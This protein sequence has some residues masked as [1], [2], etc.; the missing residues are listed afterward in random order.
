MKLVSIIVPVYNQEHYLH[1]SLSSILAQTYQEIEVV[2]VND[3]STDTS[4]AII[5]QYSAKDSRLKVVSQENRGLA[6]AIITGIRHASGDFI[7]FVDPDDFIGRHY[8]ENFLHIMSDEDDMVAM[9]F[10]FDQS[11][12]HSPYYLEKTF[13]WKASDLREFVMDVEKTKISNRIFVSRWNKLY[14]ASL[15][16]KILGRLE[17]CQDVSLGEDTLFNTLVLSELKQCRTEATPNAYYYNISNSNSMMKIDVADKVGRI[18]L[19]QMHLSRLNDELNVL[20]KNQITGLSFLL[21]EGV[22]QSLYGGKMSIMKS[23]HKK[24]VHQLNYRSVL[25]EVSQQARSFKT[26]ARLAVRSYLPGIDW[27]LRRVYQVAKK[28]AKVLLLYGVKEPLVFFKD[29]RTKGFAKSW[30]LL[31]HRQKRH[32]AYRDLKRLTPII[33]KRLDQIMSEY[34]E[35]GATYH[36][37]GL[38]QEDERNV[39][40]LWWDGFDKAPPVVKQCMASIEKHYQGYN[41]IKIDHSNFMVYTQLDQE[42][43]EGFETGKISIQTFSDVLRF[44]L[45]KL[46]GGIWMDATLFFAKPLDM[47]SYLEQQSFVSVE[48]SSSRSFYEYKGQ[49]CTWSGFLVASRRHGKLVTVMDYIFESYYK[50]YHTYDLYFFID[51]AYMYCKLNHVDDDV[52]NQ[53]IR[54]PHSMFLLMTMANRINHKMI[55]DELSEIPQKLA[56]FYRAKEQKEKTVMQ[57]LLDG[58]LLEMG[59]CNDW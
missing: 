4:L 11:G 30:E 15:V 8:I 51:L 22:M 45:L 18:E 6:G 55:I 20:E 39:F 49:Q 29:G 1:R 48:F 5:E 53:S 21:I 3:G 25:K 37:L 24:L 33:E 16:K 34:D 2:V 58:K 41:V 10:Y 7:A 31:K 23:A 19:A 52:L 42:I 9:G 17:S 54:S 13:T 57:D 14:K 46:H 40:V 12:K 59:E 56:W 28:V 27:S 44:N 47:M 43:L 35:A 36:Q 38:I 32:S 50:K 26:K